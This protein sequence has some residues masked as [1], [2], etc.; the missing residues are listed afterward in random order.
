MIER[1]YEGYVAKDETSMYES[2]PT[3]RSLK[4]EDARLDGC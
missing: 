2:G 1:G 3:E 4:G